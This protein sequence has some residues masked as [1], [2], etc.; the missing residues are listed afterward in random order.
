M[1]KSERERSH[2][3]LCISALWAFQLSLE[4]T[5]PKLSET[6]EVLVISWSHYI[7]NRIRDSQEHYRA[8]EHKTLESFITFVK[9]LK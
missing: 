1:Q 2:L 6:V 7:F 5:S 3:A 9:V 4:K 8:L